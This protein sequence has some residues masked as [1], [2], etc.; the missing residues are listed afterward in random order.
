M[1]S[2]LW[3]KPHWIQPICFSSTPGTP[4]VNWLVQIWNLKSEAIT[5]W[6][7]TPVHPKKNSLPPKFWKSHQASNS[8]LQKTPL[9]E[10]RNVRKVDS[11]LGAETC[12]FSAKRLG[13]FGIKPPS[14]SNHRNLAVKTAW[15]V[16]DWKTFKRN[17]ANAKLFDRIDVLYR[18]GILQRLKPDSPAIPIQFAHPGHRL[19]SLTALAQRDNLPPRKQI[20]FQ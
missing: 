6:I 19:D 3:G 4:G 10:S 18:E 7:P 9:P 20:A 17:L 15:E 11:S 14:T 16:D 5:C 12:R 8:K 2:I 13:P 1:P